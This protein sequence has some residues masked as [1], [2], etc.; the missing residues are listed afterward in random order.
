MKKLA[1]SPEA[2]EVST[3]PVLEPAPFAGLEVPGVL[4]AMGNDCTG[5]DSGCGIIAEGI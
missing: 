3:F 1:L 5:C 2:L 4:L